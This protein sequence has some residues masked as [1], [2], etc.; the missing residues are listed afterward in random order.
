MLF[1][2]FYKHYC[3]NLETLKLETV[4]RVNFSTPTFGDH[5]LLSIELIDK[6][7]KSETIVQKRDWS[8]YSVEGLNSNLDLN[9]RLNLKKTM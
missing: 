5:L 9:K 4:D 2:L 7:S 8:W 1:L 6:M 3:S